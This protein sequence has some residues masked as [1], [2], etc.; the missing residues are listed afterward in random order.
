MSSRGLQK[1]MVTNI[2]EPDKLREE[3]PKALELL[4]NPAKLERRSLWSSL[5]LDNPGDAPWF[6]VGDFNVIVSEEEKQGPPLQRLAA[7]LREVKRQA[8]LW[9]REVFGDIF[10]RVRKAGGEVLRLE[11]LFVN[12]PS[13]PNLIALQEVRA[14]LRNSLM[15]DEGYWRQKARVKWIREGDKNSKYFHYV[16]ADRRAKAVIHWIKGATGNWMTEDDRIAAEANE[17]L[18]KIPEMEEIREV[19]FGMDRKSA[20]G[21][22][23]FT[24]RFFT[25]VWEV[26][27]DSPQDFSQFRPISL[28]NFLNKVISKILA[29]RLAKVLPDIISP[30]QSGFVKGRQIF[31]NILLA[32]ELIADIGKT[33]RGDNIVLKIDMAKAYDRVAWPFL[34]QVLR[35]FGFCEAWTDMIWRLISNV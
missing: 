12:D 18:M 3:V 14:V 31:D 9:S 11:G 34:I 25:F 4:P 30:Q 7:K 5:L 35:R 32:Q 17:E 24:G 15:V 8:Q 26:V 6:L 10:E 29:I 13:E 19:V 23:G 33:S 16:V 20:A 22:D 2:G 1:Y 27:T 28:C 21:P